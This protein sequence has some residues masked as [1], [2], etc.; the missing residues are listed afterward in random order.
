MRNTQKSAISNQVYQA[1]KNKIMTMQLEMGESLQEESLAKEYN[2][3]RTPVRDALKKLESDGL[4]TIMPYK[5]CIVREVT[6]SDINEIYTI[7]MALEGI[8]AKNAAE[9]ISEANI[10]ELENAWKSSVEAYEKGDFSQ[11]S[12]YGDVIHNIIFHIGGGKRIIQI[13]DNLRAQ[14]QQ[15]GNMAVKLPGRLEAS[16]RQ[17]KLIVDAIKNRDGDLAS[18][19]MKEHIASTKE[20]M[21]IALRNARFR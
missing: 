1:I 16:N 15:L 6:E 10:A 9:I 5:G 11:S 2:V 8:S 3:S 19:Y 18:E 4:V 12:E 13:I 21:L 20:E 17:H 7:R 14:T